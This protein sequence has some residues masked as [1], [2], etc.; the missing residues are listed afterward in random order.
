MAVLTLAQ[1]QGFSGYAKVKLQEN[2][3]IWSLAVNKH[4]VR[5]QYPVTDKL[6]VIVPPLKLTKT[7]IISVTKH[8]I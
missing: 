4:T 3:S 5:L 7:L 6:K 2:K 1:C 8:R